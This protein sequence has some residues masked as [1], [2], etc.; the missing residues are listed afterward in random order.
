MRIVATSDFHGYLPEDLPDG[1]VLAIAGDVC[2]LSDHR[3]QFQAWWLREV[4]AAW[5]D[6]QEERYGAV[7]WIAGNHDFVLQESK[8]LGPS[9]PGTY[10]EDSGA[11]IGG[12]RFWGSPWSPRFK[13][14]AFMQDDAD[15]GSGPYALIPD[16]T[17]VLISHGPPRGCC[18]F[19]VVYAEEHVGSVALRERALEVKPRYIVCGHIH[20]AYG[21]AGLGEA[22]DVTSIFNVSIND[23]NYE[24]TNQ[25]VVLE[26]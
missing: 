8:K 13:E 3:R 12:V 24:P 1:D 23:L 9:L 11:E 15:L 25:P 26:L 16:D 19:T 5:L 2:P 21:S 18:D 20:E 22:P 14:W 17:D 6:A 7:L 10:L 4:F